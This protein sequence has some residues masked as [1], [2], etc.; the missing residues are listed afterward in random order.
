MEAPL[1]SPHLHFYPPAW[2]V[3]SGQAFTPFIITP[4]NSPH[5][6]LCSKPSDHVLDFL[7]PAKEGP[8]TVA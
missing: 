1:P 2:V 6:N 4:K 7:A 3:S 5:T 8:S